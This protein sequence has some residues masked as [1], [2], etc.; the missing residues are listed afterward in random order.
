MIEQERLEALLRSIVELLEREGFEYAAIGALARNAWG[1][2]RTTTD[3]DFALALAPSDL[4]RLLAALAAGGL[5]VRK[6][7]PSEPGD[8]VPELLLMCGKDDP[9][10]R[11]DFLVA[12]TSFEEEVLRRR[13]VATVWGLP[14]RVAT[15]E[16]LLVYKIVSNR[17]RDLDDVRNVAVARQAAGEPIDWAYVERWLKEFGCEDRLSTIRRQLDI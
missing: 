6:T 2:P 5:V 7:R 11:V 9:S 8:P 15:P 13:R 12:K 4:P 1:R 14:C 10:L 16:D 17:P 3:V